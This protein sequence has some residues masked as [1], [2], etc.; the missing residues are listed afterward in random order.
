MLFVSVVIFMEV[1][2]T[3]HFW[4][5]ICVI[6][7]TKKMLETETTELVVEGLYSVCKYVQ[8][9]VPFSTSVHVHC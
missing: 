8:A 9:E 6:N 2:K 5:D 1:N 7:V 4:S 3:H